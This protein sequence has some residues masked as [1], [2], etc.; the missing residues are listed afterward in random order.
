MMTWSPMKPA[1]LLLLLASGGCAK[2]GA[3]AWSTKNQSVVAQRRPA[4][5][6]SRSIDPLPV[7]A[8]P[9]VEA[10]ITVLIDASLSE[11]AV[12]RASAIEALRPRPGDLVEAVRMGLAD[13]NR[14]VRFVAAMMAGRAQLCDISYLVRPLLLDESQ[15]VHAAAIYAL[16]VCEIDVDPSPLGTMIM[17]SDPEVKGN[18]AMVLGV[19]GNPSAIT[20]LRWAAGQGMELAG[21]ARARMVDMQ[22][23]EAMV[24]LG[25]EREIEAIRAALFAPG[26][27]AELVAL[28]CQMVGRLDDKAALGNLIDLAVREGDRRPPSEVRLLAISAISEIDVQRVPMGIAETMVQDQN[29]EVRAQ[30]AATLGDIGDSVSLPEL[31]LLLHDPN[32]LVQVSAAGAI[33]KIA[34]SLE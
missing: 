26:E 30:A 28:A 19:L 34:A 31:E 10:A 9:A 4:A 20:M 22:I 27:D 2:S 23:A 7:L 32:P 29:W 18:A 6:T 24:R 16:S 3:E 15:S 8:G 1:V 17:S 12:L 11:S 33:L 13:E 14:G 5:A 25:E 21:P